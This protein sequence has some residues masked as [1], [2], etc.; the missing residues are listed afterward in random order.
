MLLQSHEGRIHLLPALPKAWP[1]GS[2]KGL[3]ARGAFQVD[4]EWQNGKLKSAKINSKLGNPC[5][6]CYG[7]II[8]DYETKA[9]KSIVLNGKLRQSTPVR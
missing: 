6:V 4:I 7:D 9:G 3:M 1:T 2:I 8:V 5:K